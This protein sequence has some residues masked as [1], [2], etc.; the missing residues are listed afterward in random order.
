MTQIYFH[1]SEFI[2]QLLSAVTLL[3]EPVSVAAIQAIN[4]PPPCLTDELICFGW[5]VL[6]HLHTFFVPSFS[7]RFI[8]VLFVHNTFS[9]FSHFFV[10]IVVC[11]VLRSLC[12]FVHESSDKDTPASWRLFLICWTAFEDFSLPEWGFFCNQQWRFTLV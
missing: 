1:T 3:S 5:A 9:H 2:V 11:I 7:Y 12:I 8:F 10:A 6:F 4:P